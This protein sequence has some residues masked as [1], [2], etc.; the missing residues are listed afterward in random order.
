MA[1]AKGPGHIPT[2]FNK[3]SHCTMS[4]ASISLE[5]VESATEKILKQFLN[6]EGPLN[7]PPSYSLQNPCNRGLHLSTSITLHRAKISL[8]IVKNNHLAVLVQCKSVP[9]RKE[10]VHFNCGNLVSYL[11]PLLCLKVTLLSLSLGDQWHFSMRKWV[12]TKSKGCVQWH[13]NFV[14]LFKS[15]VACR[16]L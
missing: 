11:I 2:Q 14:P 1:S 3:A 7:H 6:S 9:L 15:L 16:K 13:W 8:V 10:T 12:V 5:M 4:K